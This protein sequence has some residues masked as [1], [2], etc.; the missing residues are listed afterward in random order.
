MKFSRILVINFS[1]YIL[2]EVD[3]FK[4]TEFCSK[5]EFYVKFDLM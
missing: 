4:T 2:F 3:A 5:N 1:G